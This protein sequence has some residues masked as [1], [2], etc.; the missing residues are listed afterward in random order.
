LSLFSEAL[1]LGRHQLSPN[2]KHR[3]IYCDATMCD[4]IIDA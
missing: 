4:R 3:A 2:F 1:M